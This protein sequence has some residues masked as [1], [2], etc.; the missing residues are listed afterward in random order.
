[1]SGFE[2]IPQRVPKIS[3]QIRYPLRYHVGVNLSSKSGQLVSH[4]V[5]LRS[6]LYKISMRTFRFNSS[7]NSPL[8]GHIFVLETEI[9]DMQNSFLCLH[10]IRWI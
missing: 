10:P 2:L 1:M 4:N 8:A 5:R 7:I 6:F 9:L 3:T